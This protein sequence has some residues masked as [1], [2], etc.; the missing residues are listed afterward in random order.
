MSFA[1]NILYFLSHRNFLLSFAL[2]LGLL[3]GK[4]TWILPEISVYILAVV[5]VFATVDFSFGVFKKPAESLKALSFTFLLNYVI[6][7]G[8]LL[9]VA[10]FFFPGSELWVGCVLLAASP[11]GPSVVPFTSIM[12]GD[13]N[14]GVI[15]LFGLHLIALI[16][17][18]LILLVFT[19]NNIIDPLLI[20]IILIKTVVVPLILSRPLRHPK[21]L[22]EVRKIKG[23][24]IN[25]GFFLIIVPIVGQSKEV[26][27]A[28]PQLIWQS[29]LL[30]VLTMFGSAFLFNLTARLRGMN[31]QK[32]IASSFFLTT[33]SS[34]F[35]AVVVFA[36]ENDAAGI[37]AAVHAFFVTLFFLVYS[38]LPDLNTSNKSKQ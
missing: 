11:P 32:I 8:L 4:N 35:A 22:P 16:A 28:N 30:F 27:S 13:L 19:G 37:P 20:L 36:L 24:V 2:I 29:I 3:L 21:I 31:I 5:M 15:G 26:M 25:W 34:A 18:P 6:F 1:A 38:N 14:F 10:H 7:G 12:K 9:F 23:K 33:K 17:A